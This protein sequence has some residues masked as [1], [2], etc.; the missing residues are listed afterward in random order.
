MKRSESTVEDMF[1]LLT[2]SWNLLNEK[3]G[4]ENCVERLQSSTR[5]NQLDGDSLLL[6][7][8]ALALDKLLKTVDSFEQ[9][10]NEIEPYLFHSDKND[11]DIFIF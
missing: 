8:L 11:T 9:F 4:L 3:I 7:Y 1:Q 10:K 2:D 5:V 6:S